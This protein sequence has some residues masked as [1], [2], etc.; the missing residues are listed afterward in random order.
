M[1]VQ[2]E[3]LYRFADLWTEN[4]PLMRKSVPDFLL[5]PFV[6]LSLKRSQGLA[7]SIVT[8]LNVAALRG[9]MPRDI[10]LNPAE[11]VAPRLIDDASQ[12]RA[13]PFVRGENAVHMALAARCLVDLA[14]NHFGLLPSLQSIIALFKLKPTPFRRYYPEA[15]ACYVRARTPGTK[16]QHQMAFQR[17]FRTAVHLLSKRTKGTSSKRLT[18]DVAEICRVDRGVATHALGKARVVHRWL[19]QVDRTPEPPPVS[20]DSVA[21]WSFGL[22]EASS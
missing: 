22:R 11:V 2:R 8:L 12:F 7:V 21:L 19:R 20:N 18:A 14:N 15:C 3:S 10:F 17:G 6:T 13:L 16:T 4:L 1:Q 9:V 5:K